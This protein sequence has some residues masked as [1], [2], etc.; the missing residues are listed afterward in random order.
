MGRKIVA[1]AAALMICMPIGGGASLS[2]ADGADGVSL[3]LAPPLL[4]VRQLL[5]CLGCV[6]V[7][8]LTNYRQHSLVRHA[9]LTRRALGF[10]GSTL[11]Q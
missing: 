4:G 3:A 2:L 6:A 9:R 1:W 5:I 8:C 10:L 7:L 11:G